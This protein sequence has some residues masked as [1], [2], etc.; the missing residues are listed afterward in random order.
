MKI[1][2]RKKK[3]RLVL[4]FVALIVVF[5]ALYLAKNLFRG[6]FG[7]DKTTYVYV[8]DDKDYNQ[9]LEQLR[10]SAQ[11]HNLWLFKSMASATDLPKKLKTGRY[12]VH[13][14]DGILTVFRRIRNGSQEP[15]RLIFNNIRTKQELIDK[16]GSQFA[17]G[18]NKLSSLLNDETICQTYGLDTN[19]VVCLFIPDTYDIYWNIKPE[20]FLKKM[21]KAYNRFWNEQRTAKL[22]EDNLSK[23]DAMTLASIVEEECHFS[24]EYPMVAGLYL[25]RLH[26]GQPLQA[27]PTIKYALNNFTL[28]RIL[29]DDLKV[30]SPYN[31]Y[32][33]QGLPPGPIR[34]PSSK[35]IDGVLNYAHHNYLYMCAKEDFSQR[36]NFATTFAEHR[37]NAQKYQKALLN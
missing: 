25:N 19:T 18:K 7:I 3:L 34:I 12:V 33:H 10:D 21:E 27:D 35:A 4:S 24:D 1:D 29:L 28:H 16:I 30:V 15:V 2:S 5:S 11:I 23:T 32:I 6:G 22:A 17:F 9:L 36:H 31:T 20:A 8:T 37:M 13:P 14:S 26:S